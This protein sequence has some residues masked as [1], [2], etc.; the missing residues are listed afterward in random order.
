MKIMHL[1]F[2]CQKVFELVVNIMPS[3]VILSWVTDLVLAT[4]RYPCLFQNLLGQVGMWLWLRAG[5][6]R[7]TWLVENLLNQVGMWLW[8]RVVTIYPIRQPWPLIATGL[9]PQQLLY[10]WHTY[11]VCRFF[12]HLRNHVLQ[13]GGDLWIAGIDDRSTDQFLKYLEVSVIER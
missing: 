5:N 8:L 10:F 9:K 7:D 2:G 13:L 3:L 12:Q 1:L 4:G 6:R 11:S